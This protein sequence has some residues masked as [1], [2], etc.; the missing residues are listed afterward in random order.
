MTASSAAAPTSAVPLARWLWKSYLRVAFVPLLAIELTFLVIYWVSAHATYHHNVE[1]VGSISRDELARMARTHAETIAETLASVSGLTRLFATESARVLDPARTPNVSAEERGRYT[2]T[3][4]VFHTRPGGDAPS[5]FLSGRVPAGPRQM[6]TIWRSV[7]LDPIMRAIAGTNPLITQLYINTRDSYNRLYPGVDV[8]SVF[9]PGMDI[10][11]Y[12]FYYEADVLHNPGRQAVWTDAYID[13]AG[14]GWMVSS[15]APVYI[16]GTLEAVAGIDVT[17]KTIIDTVLDMRLPWNGYAFLVGRDGTILA[18]PQRGEEDFGLVELTDH[19]YATAIRSDTFKPEAFNIFRRQDTAALASA[20]TAGDTT[21]RRLDL[22][23][24]VLAAAAPVVGL[25]WSLV[26]IA[27]EDSILAYATALDGDLITIGTAMI[28]ILLV[29]YALFIAFLYTRSWRMSRRLATPLEQ[30]A[31]AIERIG[32]KDYGHQIPDGDI[33]ELTTVG[34]ELT[35]M[36]KRLE[37]A[38]RLQAEARRRLAES[39]DRERAL[40][41]KQRQFIDVVSHEFRTPL[42]I[43]DGSAQSLERRPET[44][45]ADRLVDRARRLRAAVRRLMEVVDSGLAFARLDQ[46]PEPRRGQTFDPEPAIATLV[47]EQMEAFP[48]RTVSFRATNLGTVW[49]DV[50]G[51]QIALGALVNNALRYSPEDSVV[52]VEAATTGDHLV[53]SVTDSGPGIADEDLANARKE[54]FRGRNSLDTHGAGVGLY[55]ADK[56]ATLNGGTL[57]IESWPGQGT[58]CV[59]SL[60]LRMPSAPDAQPLE[61]CA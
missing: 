46:G 47:A 22:K 15:I 37:E 8:L 18:L 44:M 17:I 27:P 59:L 55:I 23:T 54:F 52:T 19:D 20:V 58:R 24:P 53:L 6:D 13:P 30:F 28:V 4:T 12:N 51:F 36:A 56:W 39:L 38:D 29:F 10:P 61:E 42:A 7:D 50:L 25:G 2:F 32:A 16:D 60:P 48:L 45:T 9:E 34:R 11:S 49:G 43:I 35:K 5:A 33:A 14:G 57:S 1:T 3:G 26:V 40:N 31:A 21:A 41:T